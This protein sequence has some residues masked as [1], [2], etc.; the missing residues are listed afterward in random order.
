MEGNRS[1]E[2]VMEGSNRRKR[3]SGEREIKRKERRELNTIFVLDW[4]LRLDW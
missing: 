2:G 3:R 4:C 1:G